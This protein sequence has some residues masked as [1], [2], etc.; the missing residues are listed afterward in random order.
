M[1]NHNFESMHCV[2]NNF[3]YDS[4]ERR[5]MEKSINHGEKL[6]K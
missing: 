2:N 6:S 1:P 5:D 3:I 4:Y